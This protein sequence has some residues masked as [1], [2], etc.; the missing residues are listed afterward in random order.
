M[1]QPNKDAL[2]YINKFTLIFFSKTEFISYFIL[3][4]III[5]HIWAN[6]NLN[7]EQT[8]IFFIIAAISAPL[9]L[10]STIIINFIVLSPI[11]TYF[12]KISNKENFDDSIY[13][14]AFKRTLALPYIHSLGAFFRWNLGTT[15]VF[16]PFI[17]FGN[18]SSEQITNLFI[19]SLL[20]STVGSVYYFF[21]TEL[22]IQKLLNYKIFPKWL[23]IKSK[24]KLS[25]FQR[26]S[27]SSIAITLIPFLMLLSFIIIYSKNMQIT[28]QVMMLKLIPMGIYGLAGAAIISYFLNKTILIKINAILSFLNKVT[29][30]DLT[31]KVETI[32]IMDEVTQINFSVYDMKTSLLKI[33]TI[34]SKL[35]NDLSSSS[36]SLTSSSTKL[37]NMSQEQAATIEETSSAFEEMTSSFEINLEKVNKQL[38]NSSEIK[39]AIFKMI[40]NNSKI[41]EKIKFLKNNAEGAVSLSHDG[42]LLMSNSLSAIKELSEYMKTID[43]MISMINDIADKINLLALNAAIEA[44]RAGD[45]GKGF[46]VVADEINKLADQTNG[47]ATEIKGTISQHS[48][49]IK[50]Q[51]TNMNELSSAFS[52]VTNSVIGADKII[53]DLYSFTNELQEMNNSIVE[54]ITDMSDLSEDIQISSEQQLATNDE[55]LKAISKLNE[56]AQNTANTSENVNFTAQSLENSSNELQTNI[57]AFKLNIPNNKV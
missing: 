30:G 41:S 13:E 5:F 49:G 17:L 29:D 24:L 15:L 57:S 52:Q 40:E 51:I 20:Y 42:N 39:K 12:K 9:S 48:H 50:N 8:Q 16:G 33:I 37:N 11:T 47:L 34:I 32:A 35:T 36:N 3:V 55:L 44:A 46:A 54:N 43:S 27:I 6:M 18:L 14:K 10:I 23:N 56:V 4:P 25:L 21:S 19:I 53:F 38:L 28:F 2:K 7:Q 45:A 1:N 26:I 22:I 31:A